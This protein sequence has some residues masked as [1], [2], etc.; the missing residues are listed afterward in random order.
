MVDKKYRDKEN[1]DRNVCFENVIKKVYLSPDN[2]DVGINKLLSSVKQLTVPTCTKDDYGYFQYN[3]NEQVPKQDLNTRIENWQDVYTDNIYT[4]LKYLTPFG[5]TPIQLYI[6]TANF[7]PSN[8]QISELNVPCAFRNDKYEQYVFNEAN[9]ASFN[10]ANLKND[11]K[12]NIVGV[13]F[14][15]VRDEKIADRKHKTKEHLIAY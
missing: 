4:N 15:K 10:D 5:I 2:R 8:K 13:P 6:N 3:D 1:H 7:W 12:N 9:D 14:L 11:S